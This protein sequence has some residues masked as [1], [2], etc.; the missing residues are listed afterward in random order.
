MRNTLQPSPGRRALLAAALWFAGSGAL[1]DKPDWCGTWT[2]G[3]GAY[4]SR[5]NRPW[6]KGTFVATTWSKL[7][8]E[9]G[10]FDWSAIDKP[11][12]RAAENGLY[13][14]IKVFHAHA[15]PAWL[16]RAG[17]PEVTF[18]HKVYGK[19]ESCP[20]Y[21]HPRFKPYLVRMINAVARHI[22][23]Y[24]PHVRN[25]IVAVQGVQG[26]TGDPHPY[27]GQPTDKQFRI[28]SKSEEWR[29][30][31][32]EIFQAYWDAYKNKRPRIFLV[33]KPYEEMN[34]WVLQNMPG[35]G[36]KTHALAQGFHL[37]NEMNCEWQWKMFKGFHDGWAIRSRGEFTHAPGMKKGP[38]S[39][40]YEAPVWCTYWQCLWSLT[41]GMDTL[42]LP[43]RTL[44]KDDTYV[45]HEAAFTF[46]TTYAG[47]KD[48]RDSLGAWCALRDGLD[49][50]D[51]NRFPED[52]FG[53]VDGG[54]NAQRYLH[55]ARAFAAYG[56]EQGDPEVHLWCFECMLKR[57][58]VNA[59][60][61]NI[62][63]GN[64]GMYLSQRD[65]VETS[66]GY[67]RVGAREQPY[68][69]FARGFNHAAG[70]DTLYF[71]IDDGFFFDK[72][73]NG[74]YPV[75]VRVVYFDKGTGSWELRYDAVDAPQKTAQRVTKADTGRWLETTVRIADGAFGNRG[76]RQSD[77]LLVNTDAEDDIFHMVELTRETGDRKGY[78]GDG[79]R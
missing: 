47:Y 73:L 9:D 59:V 36:R 39:W 78:W 66:Q 35:A 21:L 14:M 51:T 57:T 33:L 69:L 44:V 46:F 28:S 8:P 63:P 38:G 55:I 79:R 61:Y 45:P 37:N 52:R 20:Y 7:E 49:C 41:Y 76:P 12:Q 17:V 64:Y 25:R 43:A 27:V 1:A 3:G 5:T 54:R 75:N 62:W 23:A 30:W 18:K 31:T 68:G 48:P 58:R 6:F 77:L 34:E 53:A 40:F 22:D 11:M 65:P 32:R 10:R 56:A 24:P 67:W 74:A 72:P 13:V 19:A 60:G 71:D 15:S 50:K 42:N 26:S 29:N 70:K 16:Y 4:I 2:W